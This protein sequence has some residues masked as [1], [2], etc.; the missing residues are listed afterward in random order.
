ME[1][2]PVPNLIVR[3]DPA[4]TEALPCSNDVDASPEAPAAYAVVYVRPETNTVL[5]ERAIVSGIRAHGR[6]AYLANLD[7]SLFRRDRILEHHYASQFRFALD[8]RA[9]LGRYPEMVRRFEEHF[10]VSFPC[11]RLAGAFEALELLSIGEEELFDT[12]VP[13]ADLLPMWG[14]ELKRIGDLVVVNPSL[15]AVA[16]RYVPGA[17]VFVA[18]AKCREHGTEALM[19]LHRTIYEAVAAR[20]ETPIL[21][22]E[23]LE[24][25]VWREKIRRTYH[26]STNHLMAAFDIADLV[27]VDAARRL[28]VTETPLG[29]LLAARGRVSGEQLRRAKEE[30]VVY[31]GS[32]DA[33]KLCY[34]PQAAEGRTVT[35]VEEM[36]SRL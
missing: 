23:L 32:G 22:A 29:R 20:R 11:A 28:D 15:P 12:I 4:A 35:Q 31:L 5:Y 18:V 21:D 2:S 3:W 33:R 24:G 25:L 30:Q 16:S 36:L 6:L 13:A 19:A 14:Q 1:T 34:L 27:Y 17:N 10:R 26:I 9:E 8:P 7:A